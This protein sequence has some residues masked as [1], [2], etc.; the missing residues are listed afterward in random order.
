M[1]DEA[2]ALKSAAQTGSVVVGI[3]E[4]W[5]AIRSKKARLV[6]IA[7]NC[8]DPKLAQE[9]SV[10]VHRFGGTNADLG[11]ACGKAFSVSALAVLDAGES[12]ILSL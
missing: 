12:N 2:R 9:R 7:N 5:A 10:K 11:A 8:P 4:V 1:I 3:K 6:V